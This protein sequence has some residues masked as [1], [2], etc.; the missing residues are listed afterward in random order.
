MKTHQNSYKKGEKIIWENSEGYIFKWN[1]QT[2]RPILDSSD[3]VNN[4]GNVN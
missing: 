3:V 2:F 1:I 4:Y